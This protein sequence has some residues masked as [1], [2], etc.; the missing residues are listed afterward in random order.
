MVPAH[1][2]LWLFRKTRSSLKQAASLMISKTRIFPYVD[3]GNIYHT[4]L[5]LN[6]LKK[7]QTVQNIALSL[8]IKDPLLV[9]TKELHLKANLLP[10]YYR[11]KYLLL[12]VCYRLVSNKSLKTITG[13]STR[14][15]TAP[16]LPPY[17]ALP[18]LTRLINNKNAFKRNIS[19]LLRNEFRNS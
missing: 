8:N 15:G 14:G 7:L 16:Y 4:G 12:T 5:P 19:K 2:Q 9:T 18:P 1:K 13:R 17:N 11:R 10:L 3:M 6:D